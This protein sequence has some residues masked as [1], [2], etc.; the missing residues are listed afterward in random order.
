[1]N[2]WID[3]VNRIGD[4]GPARIQVIPLFEDVPAMLAADA[5]LAEYL[6]DKN[7]T[8]QRVF[9]ARSDTAMNYGLV[10]AA[11]ANK[12]ALAKLAEL[13]KLEAPFVR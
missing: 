3:P 2:G 5:I 6:A 12:I 10:S 9:L 4:F 7:I 11:L 8:D 1:M 13:L